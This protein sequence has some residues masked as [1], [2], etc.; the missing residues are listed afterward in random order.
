MNQKIAILCSGGDVSGMNPALKRFVEYAYARNLQPYF[1]R[2]GYEGLIDNHIVPADYHDV[3]GIITRGGT[4][5]GSARSLRFKEA[6]YRAVA[7]E[8]LR[9]HG[10]DRLIVLGGDGS[11]RGMERFYHET[12]IA[13]CGIPSTIDN[14]I[15]GT[16]YCLG[17]DTALGVIKDAI[18]Q[19]R[20]TASSFHRAFVIETMGR[21][22]GYLTLISAITSGAE[23]CLIP[24]LPVDIDDFKGCFQ[25]QIAKGRDYFIAVVSEALDSKKVAEWFEKELGFESRV[26]VLGHIQRGGNPSVYDRLM[27][28]KFVTYA[29]DALLEGKNH[30][31]ICYNKSH[32]N[33]KTIDE[34]ALH[35]YRLDE[36][37]LNLAR[38]QFLPTRCQM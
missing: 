20:D 4:K 10:I 11:F 8:N 17:V 32:F 12:G 26:S 18:D 6:S 22:C 19:I 3:A 27:A 29:I 38:E 28:F 2:N 33:F 14:D 34:V 5:I 13:F 23:L 36:E 15:N 1:V 31:I 21:D 35:P 30:S 37:L 16:D 7:A 24:E 25:S 9:S